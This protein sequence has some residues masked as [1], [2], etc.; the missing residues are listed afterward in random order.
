[1]QHRDFFSVPAFMEEVHLF[2]SPSLSLIMCRSLSPILPP[3]FPSALYTDCNAPIFTHPFKCFVC[4]MHR[5][6]SKENTKLKH[7]DIIISLIQA[8][9][10]RVYFKLQMDR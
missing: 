7:P 4:K 8:F 1:M 9:F 10:L 3:L 2:S 5:G 6:E